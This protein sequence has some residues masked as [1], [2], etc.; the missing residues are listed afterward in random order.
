MA[1]AL[2]C[3]GRGY[4]DP[5]GKAVN[6]KPSHADAAL[7][8]AKYSGLFERYVPETAT[9]SECVSFLN[10]TGIYFGLM[11]VVNGSDFTLRDCA[12]VMG[13]MNLVFSGEAEYAAGKVRLPAGVDSWED[14]CMLNDVRYVQ[15]YENLVST[16]V[17][18]RD[19]SG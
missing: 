16:L 4:G 10:R 18:L 9:L 13:Q 14:F 17:M 6:P 7:I 19:L 1:G 3:A 2:L 8:F 15:G 5:S 11:E 12:R